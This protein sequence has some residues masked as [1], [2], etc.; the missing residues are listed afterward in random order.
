DVLNRGHGTLVKLD[1]EVF[2]GSS[3]CRGHADHEVLSK[4]ACG[5]KTEQKQENDLANSSVAHGRPTNGLE[6]RYSDNKFVFVTI[7]VEFESAAGHPSVPL[8]RSSRQPSN[9]SRRSLG[10]LWT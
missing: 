2:R 4:D 6:G 3:E 1:A 10:V 5:K 9:N 8:Y 7:L